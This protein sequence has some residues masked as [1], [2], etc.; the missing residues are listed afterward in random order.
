VM[1]SG[2]VFSTGW[3]FYAPEWIVYKKLFY[4]INK[5][6]INGLLLK[7]KYQIFRE[8]LTTRSGSLAG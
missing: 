4:F 3:R 5:G 2:E 8:H 1:Y 6:G 7:R